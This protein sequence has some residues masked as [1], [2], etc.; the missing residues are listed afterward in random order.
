MP[1]TNDEWHF[2]IGQLHFDMNMRKHS[3]YLAN[4]AEVGTNNMI[5]EKVNNKDIHVNS[6]QH[7]VD[8]ENIQPILSN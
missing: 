5:T 1:D 4:H 7:E 8:H 6:A 2:L 3:N